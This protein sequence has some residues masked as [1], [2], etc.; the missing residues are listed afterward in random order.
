MD[1]Y[2]RAD[3]LQEIYQFDNSDFLAYLAERGFYV[4][5]QAHSNYVRTAH[6]VASVLN[7]DYFMNWKVYDNQAINRSLKSF[8]IQNNRIAN[9]LKAAGYRIVYVDSG[10]S[11]TQIYS[12][13]D[14]VSRFIPINNIEK[15]LLTS[16]LIELPVKYLD[17]PVSLFDY[18]THRRTLKYAFEIMQQ[19]PAEPGPKFVFTH[20]VLPHPPFVFDQN[21]N[22]IQPDR[23]YSIDDAGDY[24]GSQE[25]Y[26]VGYLQ[27]V[28]YANRM[29]Q[30]TID[31]ILDDSPNPPIIIIQGDHGPGMLFNWNPSD[32]GCLW[33]RTSILNAYYFP[34][35]RTDELYPGITPVNSFRAILNTYFGANLDFLADKTFYSTAKDYNYM[36]DI[37]SQRDSLEKCDVVAH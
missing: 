34:D 8:P 2:G 30:L 36:E 7:F 17:L 5:S 35:H 13:D 11:V 14:F 31:S 19:M 25:E 18:P 21:G 16:S 22:P 10:F 3:V 37:T 9:T 27:Q 6:S 29:L 20:I 28:L 1:G 12:G 33:E 23:P 26:Q 15:L 24:R 4:A 32:K